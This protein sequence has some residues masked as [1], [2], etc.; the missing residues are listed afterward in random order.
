MAGEI[1][2]S[3]INRDG[4][5]KGIDIDLTKKIVN[6]VSIPVITSGGCGL[7][8]HFTDA[9]LESN[10]SGV[11]AGTFFSM[12]DQNPMQTRGHIKNSGVDIRTLT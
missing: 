6:S 12:R 10:V 4:T 2:L 8:S 1:L 7:S 9:F 3:S 5:G 11:S